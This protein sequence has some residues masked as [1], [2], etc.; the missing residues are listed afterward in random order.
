MNR[1]IIRRWINEYLDGEIGLAD[2]AELERL[3]AENPELRKEYKDLRLIGLYLGY[4]PEV[5]VHPQRFRRRVLAALDKEQGF[6]TPQRAFSMAMLVFLIVIGVTFGLFV[7]QQ[8]MLSGKTVP[9]G[10]APLSLNAL[11]GEYRFDLV[12]GVSAESYLNRLALESQFGMADNSL[13]AIFVNQTP[14]FEG[15]TCNPGGGMQALTFPR[16]LPAALIVRVSPQQALAL[17]V[18]AGELAGARITPRATSPDGETLDLKTYI[19][20]HPGDELIVLHIAF[21]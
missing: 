18:L 11:Q 6:L 8:Q 9:A 1:N 7:Y 2:K 21:R 20:S 13:L 15:A 17:G 5:Q 19:T 10:Q 4:M 14:V 12:T 16:R 3:L